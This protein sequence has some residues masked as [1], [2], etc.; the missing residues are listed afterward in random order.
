M[1]DPI[2][3]SGPSPVDPQSGAGAASGAEQ[4]R[5]EAFREALE[6]QRAG[7]TAPVSGELERLAQEVRAGRLTPEQVIDALVARQLASPPAALLSPAQRTQLEALLRS[8]LADDP[9]L[10]SMG[11]A[12][13]RAA[14]PGAR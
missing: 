5:T 6:A 8:R 12:L 14:D 3:R 1:T 7:A 2:K 9:T 4:P 11:L 13:G 10:V